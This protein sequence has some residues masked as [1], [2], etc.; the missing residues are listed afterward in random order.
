MRNLSP[1]AIAA[2]Q[3]NSGLE[4]IMVVRVYWGGSTYT[5]YCDKKFE[6][7]NLIGKLLEISGIED[8]VDINNSAN[9][10]SMSIALDDA[11]GS[12][13]QIY[14]NN[15]IHKTYTQVLQWFSSLPFSDAFIIFEGEINSPIVWEEGT[16][17]L[18][19]DIVSQLQ[20]REVGFSAEEGRFDFLPVNLIG[21]AWPI[22]FGTVAGLKALPLNESPTAVLASGFGLV[23]QEAW[24]LELAEIV[25]AI[26]DA[27]AKERSA[28][29]A[30]LGN[31][32]KAA[33]YKAFDTGGF[34]DDPQQADQYDSAA[35]SYF[36][37][38]NQYAEERVKL[39]IQL[40][41][42]QQEKEFQESLEFRVIPITQTNLPT[43][44]NLTLQINNYTMN[45]IV[46]GNALII[47]NLDQIRDVNTKPGTNVINLDTKVA[48]YDEEPLDPKF[49][50]FDGGTE[51]KVF[52][53]P[54]IF[55]VSIGAIN[56][57][58]VWAKN[59]YGRAVVPRNWYS[60]SYELFGS[61]LVTKITFP[62]PLENYPGYWE[63][64]DIEIDAAS[65]T[66]GSNVVDIM[67]WVIQNFST[68]GIDTTSFATVRAQVDAFPANFAL[69]ERMNVVDFLKSVAFQARCAIWIND[70]TFF[71]RF[72]P[73]ELAPIDTVT[74]SDVE[75]ASLSVTSVATE[76]LIT[77]FTAVWRDRIN[78]E[79]PNKIVYRYNVDR[80]G[81]HE[82]EFDFF[83]Y[84]TRALVEKAAEFWM[85]RKSNTWKLLKCKLS[86]NKL[87]I[88][89]F[90]PVEFN[91][92]ENLVS[93]GSI[94]GIVQK[95]TYDPDNDVIDLEAW[96]P[97]RLGEMVKYNFAYPGDVDQIFPVLSDPNIVTGNP[98]QDAFGQIAP[99]LVFPPHWPIVFSHAEGRT[100]TSGSAQQGNAPPPDLNSSEVVTILA[101][102]EINDLRPTGI[103]DFNNLTRPRVQE[104]TP[105]EF[106]ATTPNSF[107][108][109]VRTKKTD[110]LYTCDVYMNGLFNDP[111]STDVHI[112][113]ILE[114][115]TLPDGYPLQV[116]R[117]LY[118]D[119][120]RVPPEPFVEL[121]AQPPV[122][123]PRIVT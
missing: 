48:R 42:K 79:K 119:N 69:I 30:G 72:L 102:A 15:D 29:E 89:A 73:V 31:A 63:A 86:L 109:F 97:I 57:V 24:D 16:R 113:Y 34:P 111:T 14:D 117:S 58:N 41:L 45:G 37:Q 44:I 1:A 84:R 50:W 120:N 91:F 101:P 107:L 87:A 21:Q 71:L 114:E 8:V 60:V 52:G 121:W 7:E 106:K 3:Q 17:T 68:F 55:I 36:D 75:V 94:T 118:V 85:I 59:K 65:L 39:Q 18:K 53:F 82:E 9:S 77:K 47:S 116:Y 20:D 64:G 10:V 103:D 93:T 90:D 4:P 81:L 62:T 108:G 123:S 38:S 33:Q 112:G 100:Y 25:A 12:I 110:V 2:L 105:F 74:D 43:G 28:Y 49:T 13:K 70:R 40:S 22:V 83:I 46:V 92:T 56:V 66:L 54:R 99:I 11:D 23:G 35:S 19:F 76:Q 51:I 104:I 27:Q 88:E 80:Y 67:T 95:A 6:Q 26:A 98:W 96:L 32:F 122:W 61:L 5:N 78:Q 115:T